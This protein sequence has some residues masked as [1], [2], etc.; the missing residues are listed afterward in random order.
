M[1]Q[2][3]INNKQLLNLL[4]KYDSKLDDLQEEVEYKEMK[5]MELGIN[6]KFENQDL[7]SIEEKMKLLVGML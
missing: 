4:E 1:E 7:E 2:A 6:D 3:D 5:L